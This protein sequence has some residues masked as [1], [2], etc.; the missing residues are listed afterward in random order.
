MRYLP[1]SAQIRTK[2]QYSNLMY[3]A[4][5]H[6]LEVVTGLA[7]GDFLRTRLWE[8]LGMMNTFLSV[9]D[10][11]TAQSERQVRLAHGYKWDE[12][13]GFQELSY[14]SPPHLSGAIGLISNV[15]DYSKWIGM[16]MNSTLPISEKGHAALTTPRSILYSPGTGHDITPMAGSEMYALGWYIHHYHGNEI[17]FH[18]GNHQGFGALVGYLPRQKFGFAVMANSA[19][20]I[21][22]A[23]LALRLVENFLDTPKAKRFDW[24]NG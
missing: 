1:L 2:F 20:T 4:V 17:I 22:P 23:S 13:L 24:N 7:I 18:A 3:V 12:L 10:A 9:E 15:V 19:Q 8:P 5:S 11:Q 16:M 6:A 14:A 21:A